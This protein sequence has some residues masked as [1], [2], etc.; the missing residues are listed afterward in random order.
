MIQ[1]YKVLE[2]ISICR[3]RSAESWKNINYFAVEIVNGCRNYVESGW[4]KMKSRNGK[5]IWQNARK[6][7]I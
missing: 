7:S 4:N 6:T 5:K 1:A 2:K 3:A